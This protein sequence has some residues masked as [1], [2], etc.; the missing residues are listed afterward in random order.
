MAVYDLV[1]NISEI[2][3]SALPNFWKIAKGFLDGKYRRVRCHRFSR[4]YRSNEYPC[5][6]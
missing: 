4:H 1:K 3:M 5:T 6:I 2:M